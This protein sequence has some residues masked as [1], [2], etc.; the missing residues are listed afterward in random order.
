MGSGV[1]LQIHTLINSQ[2]RR[3]DYMCENLAEDPAF[4]DFEMYFVNGWP[5]ERFPCKSLPFDYVDHHFDLSVIDGILLKGAKVLIPAALR[6][7]STVL[8]LQTSENSQMLYAC[9]KVWIPDQNYDDIY[10]L[11]DR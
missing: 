7:N 3:L 5:L 10:R 2:S 9:N 4:K 8:P 11:I 6:L 1:H